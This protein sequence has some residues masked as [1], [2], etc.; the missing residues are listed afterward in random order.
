MEHRVHQGAEAKSALARIGLTVRDSL[1]LLAD[2]V[3]E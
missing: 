2:E 1:L 3:I